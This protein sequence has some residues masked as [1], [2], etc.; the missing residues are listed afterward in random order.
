MRLMDDEKAEELIIFGDHDASY[1]GHKASYALAYRA[2][3]QAKI[4]A[5]VEIPAE[6]GHDWNDVLFHMERSA[7]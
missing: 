2:R 1:S 4:K 6:S 7:A 3:V 5:T